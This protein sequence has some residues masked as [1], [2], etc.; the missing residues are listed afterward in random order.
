MIGQTFDKEDYETLCN[1]KA[2][3]VEDV[4]GN[5]TDE[6]HDRDNED[7]KGLIESRLETITAIMK[8]ANIKATFQAFH[9]AM[10]SVSW[11]DFV[12]E[13]VS[14]RLGE[15][16]DDAAERALIMAQLLNDNIR[17]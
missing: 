15:I 11:K 17:S 2:A 4:L 5:M 10:F 13:I 9:S 3:C 14:E 8:A 12:E 16:I 7:Q 6:A 1:I